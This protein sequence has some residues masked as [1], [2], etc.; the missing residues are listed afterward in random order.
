MNNEHNKMIA[1]QRMGCKLRLNGIAVPLLQNGYS[2]FNGTKYRQMISFHFTHIYTV[3]LQTI[4]SVIRARHASAQDKPTIE[5][6]VRYLETHLIEKLKEK[7]YVSFEDLN[8]DIKKQQR[9]SINNFFKERGSQ[10]WMHS[11]SMTNHV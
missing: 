11:K 7:I 2:I 3:H 5:N 4:L 10:D 8:T 6:H 9:S 1:Y